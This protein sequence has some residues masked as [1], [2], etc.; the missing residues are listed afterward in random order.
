MEEGGRYMTK[1]NEWEGMDYGYKGR[2]CYKFEVVSPINTLINAIVSLEN[3]LL[4]T[5]LLEYKYYW[6]P[7]LT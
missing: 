5:N 1:G 2:G 6:D 4:V 3:K 7:G